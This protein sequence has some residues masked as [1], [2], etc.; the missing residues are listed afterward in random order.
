MFAGIAN[1]NGWLTSPVSH[2][3]VRDASDRSG[4]NRIRIKMCNC[5][6]CVDSKTRGETIAHS[7]VQHAIKMGKLKN[8]KNEN[9][10]CVDCGDRAVDYDHRDYAKPLDVSPVCRRCNKKRG[11]ALPLVY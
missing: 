2:I 11:P 7:K 1:T 3:V 8:L 10:A 9:I 6:R 4:I 5:K